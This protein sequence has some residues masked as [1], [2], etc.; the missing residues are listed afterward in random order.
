M[1]LHKAKITGG[2]VSIE[3][4]STGKGREAGAWL[5]TMV[6][7]SLLQCR[8]LPFIRTAPGRP[9]IKVVDAARLK[10]H[11]GGRTTIKAF[12]EALVRLVKWGFILDF[13][14]FNK[15]FVVRLNWL[16][17]WKPDL[18]D[19]E[20][21]AYSMPLFFET[22]SSR[23]AKLGDNAIRRMVNERRV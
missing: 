12:E 5:S 17:G 7:I 19:I 16:D 3:R 18:D 14:S 11:F 21:H 2:I 9:D 15:L 6:Y 22:N 10:K 8:H 1:F 4:K 13:N 23:K 20:R